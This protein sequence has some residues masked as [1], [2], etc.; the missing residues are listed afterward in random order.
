[1]S[2]VVVWMTGLPS[3]GKSTLAGRVREELAAEGAAAITLDGDAVRAALVP[4][5]AY[6][7]VSRAEFYETLAN[8]A[9][10]AAAQGLVALVP[11]TAHKREFRELARSRAPRFVEVWLDVGADECSERDAK[12][13]YR[14]VRERSTSGLPGADLGY[15]EPD[16]PDVVAH[17]GHD[18]VAVRKIV[19]AA[20]KRG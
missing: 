9:A 20:T 18:D 6:D 7:E 5:P 2:G 19:A 17:G 4:K 13:L 12:G 15:D 3:S 14:A 10:L 16:A 8:L 11:A 1:M